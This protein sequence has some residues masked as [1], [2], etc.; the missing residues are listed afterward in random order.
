M[1]ESHLEILIRFLTER[2]ERTVENAMAEVRS[3]SET[4]NARMPE[5]EMCVAFLDYESLFPHLHGFDGS[6]FENDAAEM[7]LRLL[8]HLATSP[9]SLLLIE[10]ALDALMEALPAW[11]EPA[12]YLPL[13]ITRRMQQSSSRIAKPLAY[14]APCDYGIAVALATHADFWTDRW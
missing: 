1:T 14:Y 2:R 6:L 10:L 8:K 3:L 11:E 9:Q 13:R 5:L 4:R 12:E 7:G